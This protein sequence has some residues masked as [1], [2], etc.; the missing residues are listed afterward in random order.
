MKKFFM[1]ITICFGLFLAAPAGAVMTGTTVHGTHACVAADLSTDS[2]SLLNRWIELDNKMES[3]TLTEE[4]FA[5]GQALYLTECG[6]LLGD[7]SVTVVLIDGI[8]YLIE[9]SDGSQVI[10]NADGFVIGE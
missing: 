3:G 9:A 4:E 8:Y 2:K 1:I 5:E 6:F 10:I 7:F